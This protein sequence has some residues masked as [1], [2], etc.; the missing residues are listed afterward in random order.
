MRLPRAIGASRAI[1]MIL[2]GRAVSA[3]EAL[4]WGLVNRLVGSA[5]ARVEAEELAHKIAA[6]PQTCLRS[7]RRSAYAQWGLDE[8]QALAREFDLGQDA[9]EVEARLGA[10]RFASGAGRHGSFDDD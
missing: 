5:Q 4:E 8:Q 3:Q 1:D 9:V 2:T 6:F 10:A 7:D